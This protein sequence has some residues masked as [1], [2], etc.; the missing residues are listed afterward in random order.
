MPTDRSIPA[1][2]ITKVMPPATTPSI[3]DCWRMLVMLRLVKK[4][5]RGDDASHDHEQQKGQYDTGAGAQLLGD[6]L[7]DS[8]T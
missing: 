3:D 2:K 5:S 1:V 8:G 6:P 7:D 4:C